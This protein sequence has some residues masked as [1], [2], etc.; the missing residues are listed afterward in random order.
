MTATWPKESASADADKKDGSEASD[1]EDEDGLTYN[2]YYRPSLDERESKNGVGN[3][4]DY[5][6]IKSSDENTIETILPGVNG[7]RKS[8]VIIRSMTI[9]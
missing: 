5:I 1:E 4:K 9:L 7:V 8:D 3:R 6:S 2:F